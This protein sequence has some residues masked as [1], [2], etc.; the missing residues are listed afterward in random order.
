MNENIEPQKISNIA[1]KALIKQ[2]YSY[3]D[4]FMNH[5]ETLKSLPELEFFEEMEFII[6]PHK[7]PILFQEE[8]ANMTYLFTLNQIPKKY[9]ALDKKTKDKLNLLI[10]QLG[11]YYWDNLRKKVIYIPHNSQDKDNRENINKIEK[12][13][14]IND[15]L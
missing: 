13:K 3:L 6:T 5:D 4:D 12:Y 15:I 14:T 11:I 9:Y 7:A 10:P 2:I 1:P 8:K